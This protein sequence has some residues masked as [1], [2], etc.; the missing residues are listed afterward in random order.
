[1]AFKVESNHKEVLQELRLKLESLNDNEPILRTAGLSAVAVVLRRNQQK[2]Q[3]TDGS[4]RKTKAAK[5]SGAYSRPYAKKRK[6]KGR[7]TAIVDLTMDGDMLRNFNVVSSSPTEVNVGFLTD[8]QND[9]A[10]YAEAYYGEMF[11]LSDAEEKL[12]VDGAVAQILK[13]LE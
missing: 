13:K 11:T 1:M 4:T 8:K 12:V 10:E 6:A 7:Q 9:K 2:G 5:S 3:N